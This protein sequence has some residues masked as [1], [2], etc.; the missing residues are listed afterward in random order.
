MQNKKRIL[1][2]GG[3]AGGASCAARL[4]RLCENCEIVLFDKGEHVSFAN[5]GLPYFVGNVIK[6]EEQLLVANPELFHDRFNIQVHTRH[7]VTS[8]DRLNK[9]ITVIDL[10]TGTERT[11]AYDALVLATGAKAIRPP[12]VGIDLPGIYSLRTIPDSKKL[13]AAA[14]HAKRAVIIGGGFIGLEMAENLAHIGLEV[15]IIEMATQVM[16]PLDADM[17]G[18]VKTCLENNNISLLLGQAVQSFK[19]LA[20]GIEV[21][22][23]GGCIE[24]DLVLLA[25]GITPESSLAKQADLQVGERGG[26]RV[27]DKMQTNDTSIWAVGDVIE[28][29][30]FVT[31]QQFSLPLAGPAN[32][33]GRVAASSILEAFNPELDRKLRFKGVLG[34]AVCQVFEHTIAMTGASEKLL[35]RTG[36]DNYQVIYLHPRHHVGYFPGAHSI[37]LK[38]IF[39]KADGKILG[40]QGFGQEG[41]A[42]RIDVIAMA[43]QMHATVYDLED[44]ELCYAPQFGAAKDPVNMAGMIAANHL[45]GDLP[46][47]QWQDLKAGEHQVVD[48]RSNAEYAKEHIVDAINIPIEELR[49]RLYELGKDKELWLVCGVGQRAYYALR[50]LLQ[51]GYQAKILSGGMQ[52]YKAMEMQSSHSLISTSSAVS[53]GWGNNSQS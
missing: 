42:R 44:S 19:Q 52:T 33:Q 46:L 12:L 2:V 17:A 45:R 9:S 24:T 31:Q 30:D 10:E 5:C 20:K 38:L 28:V 23:S 50:L 53:P 14:S 36:I 35:Q 18:Y 15:T 48:V 26:I 29:Q 8:I 25:I 7:E 49:A 16:P 47:A 51:A 32:R 6:E 41:V 3:V 22:Y 13:K 43:M 4:R 27:D 11:E 21:H 39:A 34:T 1:I 37:H 40:V